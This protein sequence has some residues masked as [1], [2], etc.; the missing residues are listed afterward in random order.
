MRGYRDGQ[1]WYVENNGDYCDGGYGNDYRTV[2]H[3]S[4]ASPYAHP[5]AWMHLPAAPGTGLPP[6][7]QI[8]GRY[9]CSGCQKV[10]AECQ[11]PAAPG[12]GEVEA[13]IHDNAKLLSAC[14]FETTARLSAEAEV[15]RLQRFLE[16]IKAGYC[17]NHTS[18]WVM[19]VVDTAL[20]PSA[21]RDEKTGGGE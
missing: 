6:I 14:T 5:S 8:N 10:G 13:L 18:Q 9:V 20:A 15:E 12:D 19:S 11:C 3:S 1:C 16:Q 17:V 2:A 7:A 4:D 21:A